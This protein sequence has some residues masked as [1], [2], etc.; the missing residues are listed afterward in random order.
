[1]V[2]ILPN[3]ITNTDS[4]I[5]HA[6]LSVWWNKDFKTRRRLYHKN[7][8]RFNFTEEYLKFSNFLLWLDSL[9]LPIPDDMITEYIISNKEDRAEMI[10]RKKN[11]IRRSQRVP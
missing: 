2:Q 7:I 9:S 10:A 1:M 8:D 11:A 4:S 3:G 5:A 6:I